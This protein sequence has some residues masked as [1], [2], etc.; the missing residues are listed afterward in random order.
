ML[1]IALHF[2]VVKW[3][4]RSKQRFG[5]IGL[6]KGCLNSKAIGCKYLSF[7]DCYTATSLKR[8][9]VQ[10]N[11]RRTEVLLWLSNLPRHVTSTLDLEV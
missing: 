11:I 9:P 3:L 7:K 6:W 5:R 1:A 4:K 8:S 10:N 2:F